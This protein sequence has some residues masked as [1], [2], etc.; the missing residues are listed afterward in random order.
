MQEGT[1]NVV[2]RG[3]AP[4][5]FYGTGWNQRHRG[6]RACLRRGVTVLGL[7]LLVAV[8]CVAFLMG[9]SWVRSQEAVGVVRT[10]M[11]AIRN[12]KVEQAYALFSQDYQAGVSLPMFRRWL[13]REARLTKVEQIQFWGRS[14]WRST[15]VLWGSFQDELGHSYPVRYLLIRENGY[16]RIDSFHLSAEAPDP[17]P[18]Y[19]RFL[20]I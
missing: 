14:V 17:I 12:G 5:A 3:A 13:R 9:I 7:A 4:P 16:W 8:G 19:E 18:E 1:R 15:A 11:D 10:Q 2:R 20:Y 6:A